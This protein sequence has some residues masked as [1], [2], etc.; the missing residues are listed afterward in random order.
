MAFKIYSIVIAIFLG[1]GLTLLLPYFVKSK[2]Q[3]PAGFLL[4]YFLYAAHDYY[5]SVYA[6]A[7]HYR[8]I[9][10]VV[11]YIAVWLIFKI[12]FQ[13]KGF[14]NF[15]IACS[16]DFIFQAIGTFVSAVILLPITQLEP[17]IMEEITDTPSIGAYFL[18][19]FSVVIAFFL[20]RVIA[21]Q[22]FKEN[23]RVTRILTAIIT[24]VGFIPGLLN[25]GKSIYYVFLPLAA[26]MMGSLFYQEKRIKQSE[27]EN[28]YYYKL[29]G[30]LQLQQEEL[31][32]FRH[33]IANHISVIAS[34]KDLDY[35]DEVLKEIDKNLRSGILIIDRLIEEKDLLCN[36]KRISF[37]WELIDLSKSCIKKMEWVSLL[38]NAVDNAIEACEGALDSKSIELQMKRRASY[39]VIRLNNSKDKNSKPADRNFISTKLPGQG[40]GYGIKIMKEIVGRYDGRIRYEDAGNKMS[41]YITLQAWE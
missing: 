34:S 3:K 12:F 8:Y 13:G 16:L 38:S 29:E 32:K 41:T 37:H 22:L 28:E 24:L 33:D 30:K 2:K 6:E 20:T 9:E 18:L 25:S 23:T 7:F 5:M 14:I 35:R 39:I 10:F 11:Y 36:V 26:I 31:S 27:K 19:L 4:F 17:Y 40:H 15:T 1:G 21:G